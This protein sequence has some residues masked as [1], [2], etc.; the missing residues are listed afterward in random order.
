[1]D[2][3]ILTELQEFLY[4]VR[5]ISTTL[6]HHC[7]LGYKCVWTSVFKW[8]KW[9]EVKVAQPCQN[10]CNPRDCVPPGSSVHGIFQARILDW[11][12]ISFFR[13]SS[14]SRD[15]SW[16]SCIGGRVSAIWV[17]GEALW[18]DYLKLILMFHIMLIFKKFICNI[19]NRCLFMSIAD[20]LLA[21]F[22]I[23]LLRILVRIVGSLLNTEKKILK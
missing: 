7:L 22:F 12:A 18:N 21:L 10:L 14:Q 3:V 2:G 17:T 11:V 19:K 16:V 20:L 15:W 6:K 8:L 13:G 1:M 5:M 9:R 4:R 23:H